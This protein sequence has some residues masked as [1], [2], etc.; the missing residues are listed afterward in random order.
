MKTQLTQQIPCMRSCDH[1]FLPEFSRLIIF[2]HEGPAILYDTSSS[3]PTEMLNINHVVKD[4]G[5]I[6]VNVAALSGTIAAFA[7][8]C[9]KPNVLVLAD[10]QS[11]HSKA[12]STPVGNSAHMIAFSPGG[13][14]LALGSGIE[15]SKVCIYDVKTGNLVASFDGCEPFCWKDDDTL[16]YWNRSSNSVNCKLIR[17]GTDQIVAPIEFG[18]LS[19]ILY[20]EGNVFFSVNQDYQ[21]GGGSELFCVSLDGSDL[22]SLSKFGVGIEFISPVDNERIVVASSWHGD[23]EENGKIRMF[24][25]RDNSITL[26][27]IYSSGYGHEHLYSPYATC[28]TESSVWFAWRSRRA[29]VFI[30]KLGTPPTEVLLPNY[31]EE[32]EAVDFPDDQYVVNSVHMTLFNDKICMSIGQ[33]TNILVYEIENT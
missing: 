19:A 33:G 20:F 17:S 18:W 24:S 14:L 1:Y 3:M 23:S 25:L 21:A 8:Y 30:A 11:G 26:I 6:F 29:K 22:I 7:D 31:Y 2:G 10:L 28:S 12:I 32:I 9:S 16:F 15:K 5:G 4:N 27:G 13:T